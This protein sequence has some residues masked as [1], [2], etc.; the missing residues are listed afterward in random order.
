VIH[1]LAD[2]DYVMTWYHFTGAYTAPAMGF[3]AGDPIDLKSIELARLK[4]GKV[5]E[6]WS[7]MEPGDVVKMMASMKPQ[8]PDMGKDATKK[9]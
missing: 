1:E 2:S 4:D 3:K 9:K 5:V 8:M 6:H 7:M